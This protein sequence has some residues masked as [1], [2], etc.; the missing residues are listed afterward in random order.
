[1]ILDEMIQEIQNADKLAILTHENLDG[2]AV[3]K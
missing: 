2:D 3:R 1:M